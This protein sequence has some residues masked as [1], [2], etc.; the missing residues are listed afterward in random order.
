MY[1]N[2]WNDMK[3]VNVT[4][5]THSYQSDLGPAPI[6]FPCRQAVPSSTTLPTPAAQD[7]CPTELPTEL[8][9]TSTPFLRGAIPGHT[10]IALVL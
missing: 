1:N 7:K 3:S 4:L 2:S 9:L 10:Y 8:P 5:T 6:V